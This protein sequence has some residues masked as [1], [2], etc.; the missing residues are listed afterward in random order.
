MRPDKHF[1]GVKHG[2]DWFGAPGGRGRV[3]GRVLKKESSMRVCVESFENIKPQGEAP[4]HK[5][6]DPIYA[7]LME[8]RRNASGTQHLEFVDK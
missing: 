7:S 1:L 6:C 2:F 3:Y 5:V 8:E 4:T